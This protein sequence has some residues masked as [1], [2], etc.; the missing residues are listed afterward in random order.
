MKTPSTHRELVDAGT[1]GDAIGVRA[2]TIRQWAREGRIPALQL[3]ARI[4]RFDLAEVLATL[5]RETAIGRGAA[6]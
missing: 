2:A 3:S 6:Q 1:V 5:K 4:M